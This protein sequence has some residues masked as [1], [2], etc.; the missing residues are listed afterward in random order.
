MCC[1]YVVQILTNMLRKMK[2]LKC[3]VGH[4]NDL[5]TLS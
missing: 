2:M 1:T 4:Q 5:N 3:F